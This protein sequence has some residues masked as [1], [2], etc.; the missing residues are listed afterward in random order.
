LG[1]KEEAGGKSNRKEEICEAQKKVVHTKKLKR[2]GIKD[3]IR[4]L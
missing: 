4:S 1:K 3:L 2:E